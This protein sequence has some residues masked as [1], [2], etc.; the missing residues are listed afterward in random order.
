MP[1]KCFPTLLGVPTQHKNIY[2]RLKSLFLNGNILLKAA[3][4]KDEVESLDVKL[5]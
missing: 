5:L 2:F 3:A 1:G 4:V